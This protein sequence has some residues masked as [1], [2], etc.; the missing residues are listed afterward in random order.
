MISALQEILN[1]LNICSPAGDMPK[2]ITT[3]MFDVMDQMGGIN[4]LT[5]SI[6]T[7]GKQLPCS[8]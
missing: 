3:I 4:V 7:A 8:T 2:K 5:L 6:I 1:L